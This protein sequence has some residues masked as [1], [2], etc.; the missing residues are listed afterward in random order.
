MLR[1]QGR[2]AEAIEA[3]REAIRLRPNF[4]EARW[5]LSHLL[6]LTGEFVAGWNESDWWRCDL[7]PFCYP[8]DRKL[9]AW[10]GTSFVGRRLLILW[11]RGFGDNLQ[12]VRYLP[13]GQSPR[14]YSDPGG[15]PVD[16]GPPR[17]Y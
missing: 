8:P 2:A 12:F 17:P 7:R 1:D 4:P 9:Q 16:E 14:R 11:E 6:L 3:T 15:T 13:E 5:N 10:D